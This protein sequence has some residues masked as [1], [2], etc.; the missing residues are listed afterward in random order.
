LRTRLQPGGNLPQVV[1]SFPSLWATGEEG[2]SHEHIRE[3]SRRKRRCP[4]MASYPNKHMTL[5]R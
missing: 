5:R 3:P 1:V 2:E 4:W